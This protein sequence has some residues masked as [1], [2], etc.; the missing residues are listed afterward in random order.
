GETFRA[1]AAEHLYRR[2]LLEV[3]RMAGP[4]LLARTVSFAGAIFAAGVRTGLPARIR[5]NISDC[6]RRFRILPISFRRVL[7]QAVYANAA[8]V[9]IRLQGSR[10][11]YLQDLPGARPLRAT[12][13]ER[14]S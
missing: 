2:Q 10:T 5:G 7:A 8:K 4:D 1:G 9:S 11:D 14:E 13:G 12:G 6:V 3:R